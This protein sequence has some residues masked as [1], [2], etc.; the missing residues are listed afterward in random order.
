MYVQTAYT[1]KNALARNIQR[2]LLVSMNFG[3]RK[4]SDMMSLIYLIGVIYM[5][6][7]NITPA[8]YYLIEWALFSIADAIWVKGWRR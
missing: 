4:W 8:Q 7:N 1:K 6:V 5:Y 3:C 2:V